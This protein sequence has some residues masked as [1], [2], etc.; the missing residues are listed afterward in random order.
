MSG[1][2]KPP[3]PRRLTPAHCPG[4]L[5]GGCQGINLAREG[6]QFFFLGHVLWIL[7]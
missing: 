7:F 4:E 1:P 2:K 5:I 3:M 6:V